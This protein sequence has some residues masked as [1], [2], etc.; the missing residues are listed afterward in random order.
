MPNV[1]IAPKQPSQFLQPC[2]VLPYPH[3]FVEGN[4]LENEIS[5][6]VQNK[7]KLLKSIFG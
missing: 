1:D 2:T 6:K 5:F 4:N 7:N 3:P